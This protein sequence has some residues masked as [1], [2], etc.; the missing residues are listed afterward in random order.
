LQGSVRRIE[1][2]CR[3]GAVTL[4]KGGNSRYEQPSKTVDD[5]LPGDSHNSPV[6]FRE[7]DH[8]CPAAPGGR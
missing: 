2:S 7:P 6:D 4:I 8:R 1:K 5:L 3:F